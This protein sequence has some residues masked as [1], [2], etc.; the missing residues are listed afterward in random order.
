MEGE[1]PPDLCF[2]PHF[3]VRCQE[4]TFCKTYRWACSWIGGDEDQ[5][6]DSC[7]GII[8]EEM[9]QHE[10]ELEAADDT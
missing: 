3:C 10:R 5:Y 9:E 1:Q 7:M 8:A 4:E 2:E 6:C